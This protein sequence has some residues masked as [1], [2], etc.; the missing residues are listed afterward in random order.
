MRYRSMPG[1]L[2]ALAGVVILSSRIFAQSPDLA[3]EN[4]QYTK[5]VIAKNHLSAG[6]I[7]RVGQEDYD[8]YEYER[9][10][11]LEKITRRGQVYAHPTGKAWEALDNSGKT[12]EVDPKIVEHLNMLVRIA[13]SAFLIPEPLDL[14]QSGFAWKFIKPVA[15]ENY[16]LSVYELT[17]QRADGGQVNPRYTFIKAKDD[18]DGNLLLSFYETQIRSEDKLVSVEVKF[19]YEGIRPEGSAGSEMWITGEVFIQNN[20]LFLRADRTVTGN[21]LK[22]VILLQTTQTSAKGLLPMLTE[23]ATT[24]VKLRLYGKLATFSGSIAGNTAPLPNVRF[25]VWKLHLPSDPDD[26]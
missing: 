10:P 25:V 15:G 19:K 9:Y 8:R 14:A 22:N 3:G 21:P 13:N 17:N 6:V 18:K 4:L 20:I 24:H 26:L 11:D 2:I 5:A 12:G 7:L 23:A 1:M 16:E